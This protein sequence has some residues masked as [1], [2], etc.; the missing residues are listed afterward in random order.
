MERKPI[1]KKGYQKIQDEVQYLI[2]VDRPKIIED[3]AEA[4]AHGD[5]KENAEFHAAKERQGWIEGRIQQINFLLANSEIFDPSKVT[6]DDIKFGAT[7]TYEDLDTEE[8]TT[9]QIVGEEE[10]EFKER[11]ISV[12]SPIARALIGRKVGDE[13]LIKVPKG[14]IEVEITDIQYK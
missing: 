2:K 10:S 5:L 13:V 1:T 7:V 3:I 8:E 4:R 14:E 9:W 12:K 11:K 6:A